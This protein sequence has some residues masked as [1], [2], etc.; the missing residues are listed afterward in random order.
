MDET[1]M[2]QALSETTQNLRVLDKQYKAYLPP[3]GGATVYF[4]G[5][6][7]KL[8]D[9][10]TEVAVRVHD[11]Q[12]LFP[13]LLSHSLPAVCIF[14]SCPAFHA[15]SEFPRSTVRVTLHLKPRDTRRHSVHNRC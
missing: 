2:R 3:V 15:E 5:D 14:L 4:I 7:A 6:I 11:G 13:I 9:P 8:N 10:A 12:F 1:E